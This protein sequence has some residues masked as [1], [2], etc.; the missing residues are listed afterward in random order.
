[1]LISHALAVWHGTILDD[2]LPVRWSH[3]M[4]VPVC[5]ASS[6]V[7]SEPPSC[8]VLTRLRCAQTVCCELVEA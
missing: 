1:M 6:R 8:I 5:C 3:K 7:M 4:P 2:L